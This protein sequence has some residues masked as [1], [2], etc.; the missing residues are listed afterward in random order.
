MRIE[1]V[2]HP[3]MVCKMGSFLGHTFA[4]TLR[5]WYF[6][7]RAYSVIDFPFE[8]PFSQAFGNCFMSDKSINLV[9]Y[10]FLF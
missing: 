9:K 1:C 4:K 2:A 8:S 6:L 10:F 5:G 7:Q 3:T